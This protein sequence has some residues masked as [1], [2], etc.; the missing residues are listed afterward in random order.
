LVF[1]L[2]I[3]NFKLAKTALL[4]LNPGRSPLLEAKHFLKLSWP[5]CNK[6]QNFLCKLS[7]EEQ[8]LVSHSPFSAALNAS[9]F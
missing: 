3:L 8:N 2:I 1:L 7:K 6:L 5:V 4:Q 9:A